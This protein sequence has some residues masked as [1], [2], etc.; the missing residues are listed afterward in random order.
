MGKSG[1][2]QT[3]TTNSALDPQTQKYVDEIMGAARAAGSAPGVGLSPETQRAMELFSNWATQ[4]GRGMSALGGDQNA[5]NS[6]YNPFQQ[7]VVDRTVGDFGRLNEGVMSSV[8]DAATQAG[9]FGGSRHGIATGTA[10][11]DMNRTG[12]DTLAG[13]RYQGFNDAMGRA[14]AAANLGFGAAGGLA[15][16]GAYS[17][18]VN[19]E[20]DPA[21]RQFAALKAGFT[22]LP[23]GQSSTQTSQ[24]HL[25]GIQQFM[26]GAG[27]VLGIGSM[28][29]PGGQLAGAA[30][31]L[32]G[33]F[34]MGGG[35]V[36]LPPLNTTPQYTPSYTTPRRPA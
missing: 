18:Q 10:L 9:A 3:V 13:L 33:L 8:N 27:N 11:A 15:D 12:Q 23:F 14:G 19:V 29:L 22:G 1:G 2:K 30:G 21:A 17:R 5:I 34:G 26:Q 25:S 32:G 31:A 6:F 20:N 36:N 28:F 35:G 16:L 4:G 24:Q 7:N